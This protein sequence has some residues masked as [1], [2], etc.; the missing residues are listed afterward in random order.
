M[1]TIYINAFVTGAIIMSFE[2]IGSRYINP[3][4]GSGIFTW[5][6]IISTVLIALMLAYFLG[7]WVADKAPRQRVLGMFVFFSSIYLCIAPYFANPLFEFVFNSIEDVRMG[8]LTAALS[9]MALPI[10]GMGVYSPFAIRLVLNNTQN[11]GSIA[12]RVYGISTAG[13]I[14][15]TLGT[16]FFLIPMMGTHNLTILL[17]AIGILSG[18]S[19]MARK[20]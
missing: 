13:S 18:L 2:M 4:F 1:F 7:G 15:G 3:F 10:I 11:S 16:T 14:F 5:A 19:L 12:G 8:S 6:S 9:L 20:S 17:G